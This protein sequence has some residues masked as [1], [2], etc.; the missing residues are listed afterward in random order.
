[1]LQPLIFLVVA[2][3][4]L[5]LV[6]GWAVALVKKVGGCLVHLL[7]LAAGLILLVYLGSLYLQRL[8]LI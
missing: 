7:L 8:G 3:L 5:F 1:M 4:I 2:A 6:L